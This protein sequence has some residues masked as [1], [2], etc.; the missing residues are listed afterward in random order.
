VK[1]LETATGQ[2]SA[3]AQLTEDGLQSAQSLDVD[4]AGRVYVLDRIRRTVMVY[5]P[6]GTFSRRIGGSDTLR[7]PR[8]IAV[9]SVRSRLYIA[10]LDEHRVTAWGL[11]GEHLFDLTDPSQGLTAPLDLAINSKGLVYV[12]SWGQMKIH[13]FSPAGSYLRGFGERGVWPK[14]LIAPKGISI[15]SDDN[16]YVADAAFGNVQ[17][18]DK[19][20]RL[21]LYFGKTGSELG[22]LS[23]PSQLEIDSQDRIFI[24]EL[25]TNRVQI[26][27]YLSL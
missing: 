2:L 27:Q 20:D 25:G 3:F 11:T 26:F 18:F 23:L 12:L 14:Q 19:L 21:C 17:I 24:P 5:G 9:D 8:S 10:D 7:G 16:V 1:K 22:Q 6:D 15:D 13:I 4:E